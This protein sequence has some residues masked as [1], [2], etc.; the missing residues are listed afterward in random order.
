MV[1]QVGQEDF[2]RVIRAPRRLYGVNAQVFHDQ[3]EAA[4]GSVHKVVVIDMSDLIYISNAGLRVIIQAAKQLQA[5]DAR[6]V[7][8]ALSDE[9]QAL[10]EASSVDRV[11]DIRPSLDVA[12]AARR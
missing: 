1:M 12:V 9:V 5:H 7:L 6:L 4:V 2:S 3:L 8:C 11:I 10:F